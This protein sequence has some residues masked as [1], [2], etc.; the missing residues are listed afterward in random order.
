MKALLSESRRKNR[1]CG[2]WPY[3]RPPR[4][5]QQWLLSAESVKNLRQQDSDSGMS[6]ISIDVLSRH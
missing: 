5:M 2:L 4:K 6:K 1:S 3:S